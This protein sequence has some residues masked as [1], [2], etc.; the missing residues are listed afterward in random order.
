MAPFSC[1]VELFHIGSTFFSSAHLHISLTYR[2]KSDTILIVH[3]QAPDG[4]AVNS[5]VE[6]GTNQGSDP[7]GTK[8]K[9]A[10]LSS[11]GSVVFWAFEAALGALG[12]RV[13]CTPHDDRL[14]Q[15]F[16]ARRWL[17]LLLVMQ[18]RGGSLSP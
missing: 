18:C 16:L 6:G 10:H 13:T 11:C 14:S 9:T 7:G 2:N 4:T 5:P 1:I 12:L 15:P 17:S 8:K 3:S